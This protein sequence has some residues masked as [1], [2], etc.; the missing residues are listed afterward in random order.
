[1]QVGGR[2]RSSRG[3][4]GRRGCCTL[5]LHLAGGLPLLRQLRPMTAAADV[6]HVLAECGASRQHVWDRDAEVICVG[7]SNLVMRG[8]L[9]GGRA[10]TGMPVLL[11]AG[12]FA[13]FSTDRAAVKMAMLAAA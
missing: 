6:D 12:Q 5:L 3:D 4:V 11:C 7:D 8:D 10:G 13:R 2:S 1:V 9:A